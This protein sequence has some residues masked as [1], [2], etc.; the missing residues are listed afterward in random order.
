VPSCDG[1][2]NVRQLI[3][4]T[5]AQFELVGFGGGFAGVLMDVPDRHLSLIATLSPIAPPIAINIVIPAKAGIQI[6]C[7]RR[8]V[9]RSSWHVNALHFLNLNYCVNQ[10][11]DRS[12]AV[13]QRTMHCQER[14]QS[15]LWPQRILILFATANR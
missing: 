13:S 5:A 11:S 6:R 9:V 7:T 1:V 8:E 14:K 15:P 12:F 4:R 10:S 3:L 2:G